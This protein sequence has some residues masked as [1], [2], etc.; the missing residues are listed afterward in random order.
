MRSL[1]E[2]LL[3]LDRIAPLRTAEDWD[4]VGLLLGDPSD[5][6]TNVMTCLTVT[7]QVIAEAIET[8]VNLLVSHHPIPFKPL[9]RITS[10]TTTG[11][12]LLNAARNRIAIYSPHTAWDNATEGINQQLASML[13]LAKVQPMVK[14]VGK[15][16]TEGSGRMGQFEAPVSLGE[17]RQSLLA[18]VPN[19]QWRSTH[20]DERSI[21]SL[22]ILCGSGGSFV[23]AAKKVGCDALL[24]GE[25]TY[26]QCLE[27]E[28][29][30]V[31][32]L[33]MG[34]F[35]SEAFAMKKLA[36]MIAA[37]FP[38]LSVRASEIEHSDF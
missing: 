33:L 5:V 4:N 34:H 1:Q 13:K 27:A 8:G 16:Q 23:A 14:S 38:D 22:G 2:I 19:L 20:T 26:H 9:Q 37:S 15:E 30:G 24:T 12:L 10:D 21:R 29:L 36:A 18:N 3:E 11:R 28:S 7:D 35:A 25:A 31:A 6:I 17:I 32:L